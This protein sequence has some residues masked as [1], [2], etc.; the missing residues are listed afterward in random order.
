MYSKD[1]IEKVRELY[2]QNKNIRKTSRILNINYS[3]VNYMI[4][5]DYARVKIKPGPKKS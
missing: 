1:L 2:N 4:K 5:N 3:T